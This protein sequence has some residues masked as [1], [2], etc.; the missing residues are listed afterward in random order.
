MNT[1]AFAGRCSELQRKQ[2][3]RLTPAQRD[4]LLR[5]HLAGKTAGQCARKFGVSRSY[6]RFLAYVERHGRPSRAR[7][8][9]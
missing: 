1:L 3:G 4:Q 7:V 5:E 9:A 2:R 6:P 8:S